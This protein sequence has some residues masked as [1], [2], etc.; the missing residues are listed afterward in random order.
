MNSR[1]VLENLL[2]KDPTV[3]KQLREIAELPKDEIPEAMHQFELKHGIELDSRDFELKDE[4]LEKVAGGLDGM[5]FFDLFTGIWEMFTP[6]TGRGTKD[7][8]KR[9]N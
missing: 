4:E 8:T 1:E 9:F 7:G 2:K 5:D 6:S 3:E